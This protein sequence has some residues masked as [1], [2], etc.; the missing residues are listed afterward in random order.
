MQLL[1]VGKCILII[2]ASAAVF[3]IVAIVDS[4]L[5]A[6]PSQPIWIRSCSLSAAE[7]NR[8]AITCVQGDGYEV[9]HKYVDTH[10]VP[11]VIR[12][13]LEGQSVQITCRAYQTRGPLSGLS[14]ECGK[15]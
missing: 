15:P 1:G 5:Y 12:E 3:T 14:L 10:E 6:T 8:A 9:V 13:A 7:K 4:F 11:R 2:V